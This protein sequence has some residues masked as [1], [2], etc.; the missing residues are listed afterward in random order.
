M[1]ESRN[2]NTQASSFADQERSEVPA[3]VPRGRFRIRPPIRKFDMVYVELLYLR[4]LFS[5]NVLFSAC[6]SNNPEHDEVKVGS[7]VDKQGRIVCSIR[8]NTPFAA[9]DETI[10]TNL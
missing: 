9:F 2:R 10:G 4:E 7:A 1:C 3:H 5:E 6:I 8:R